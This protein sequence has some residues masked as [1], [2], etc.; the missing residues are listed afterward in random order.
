M[1][2]YSLEELVRLSEERAGT[3]GI[4]PTVLLALKD[5]ATLRMLYLQDFPEVVNKAF[6]V[7]PFIMEDV[8]AQRI[9]RNLDR[10]SIGPDSRGFVHLVIYGFDSYAQAV[11]VMAARVAHFPNNRRTRITFVS[12][13]I[14]TEKDKFIARYRALFDNSYYRVIDVAQRQSV[15]HHPMYEGRRGDFVD[16]E[17]EFADA[18]LS[19]P[20]VVDKLRFW[21]N[22]SMRQLTVVVSS[23]D[24]S[25][26]LDTALALP[27][28]LS[29]VPVWVRMRK[30]IPGLQ[31]LQP[32][33]MDTDDFGEQEKLLEMA[34]LLHYC[35]VC[36]RTKEGL[37]TFFPADEVEKAWESAGPLKMRLSNVYNVLTMQ[38]KMHSLGHDA[39]DLK[40]FYALTE[41]E[42]NILTRTEHNRWC[43]E[44]LLAGTRPCTDQEREAIGKDISLKGEY[45]KKGAHYDLCSYDE[46]GCDETGKDVRDYDRELTACIPLIV[47]SVMKEGGR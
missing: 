7:M 41:E 3:D 34:K 13:G 15:L 38:T 46:L 23:K 2:V 35:Y 39:S 42:V 10:E 29:D 22:D 47:E 16:V 11:A 6:N 30:E 8:W 28:E 24:D 33:G 25:D 37:P 14:S 36:S 18:S 19:T 1:T 21:A 27:E 44:R 12:P 9:V 32:F 40:S 45:K 43:V 5:A 26:N 31:R 17:W 20:D 4:R